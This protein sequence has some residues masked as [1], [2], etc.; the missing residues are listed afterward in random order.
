VGGN[1][2]ITPEE[3]FFTQGSN[4]FRMLID[5]S[6]GFLYILD[7]DAPSSKYC[8]VV[9]TATCGDI[10]VFSIDSTTG[11]LSLVTNSQLTTSSGTSVTYFPVP[12]N[13]VDFAVMGSNV[14]TLSSATAQTSYPYSGGSS[15]FAYNFTASTGQLTV[16]SNSSQSLQIGAGTA[17]ESA[18]GNVYVLDN[19]PVT[20]TFNGTSTTSAS[21]ILPYT[22]GSGGALQMATSGIV[23]DDPTLANP[24]YLMVEAKGKFVYVINQGNNTV[25]ANAQSGVAGYFISSSPSFQ[26]SFIAGQ[27]FGSGA[28][29]QCIVEDPSNQ[30]IYEANYNDSTI[31]GR[32]LDPNSGVLNNMRVNSVFQLNGPATWCLINSRTN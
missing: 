25:G 20:R 23:P 3:T 18:G 2:I 10:T 21:Q 12:A 19:E 5:S 16:T 15:V 32:V 14:L 17:I 11:R 22:V 6:G 8:N 24:I 1:G 13:P 26:L 4:P 9:G 28:G 29:P 27:P 31:T 30:F 7:H